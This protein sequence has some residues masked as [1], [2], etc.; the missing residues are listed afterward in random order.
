MSLA[1]HINPWV[2]LQIPWVD[3]FASWRSPDAP[4]LWRIVTDNQGPHLGTAGESQLLGL[5]H[6]SL[7][8]I[9][10]SPT[11]NLWSVSTHWFSRS[12]DG[13]PLCQL[14]SLR[15]GAVHL[16]SSNACP[17]TGGVAVMGTLLYT[18]ISNQW[19]KISLANNATPS[20][21]YIDSSMV[22]HT[23]TYSILDYIHLI[24]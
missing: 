14:G 10:D 24:T 1:L 21:F 6:W 17:R 15:P 9:A 16:G 11:T 22:N 20:S 5:S 4:A 12:S 13:I 2:G 8:N 18:F 7:V 23:F 3:D 19:H